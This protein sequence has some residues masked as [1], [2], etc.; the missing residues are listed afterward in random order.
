MSILNHKE[1][2]IDLLYYPVESPTHIPPLPHKWGIRGT[3]T[4]SCIYGEATIGFSSKEYLAVS[5]D[6]KWEDIRGVIR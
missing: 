3:A 4:I 5:Y 2:C 1:L 6:G